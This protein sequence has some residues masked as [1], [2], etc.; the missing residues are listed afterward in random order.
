MYRSFQTIPWASLAGP[1]PSII[2]PTCSQGKLSG[3]GLLVTAGSP[4]GNESLGAYTPVLS[5][6]SSMG[7]LLP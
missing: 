6:P 4:L 3:V 5:S 7:A 2:G 1:S